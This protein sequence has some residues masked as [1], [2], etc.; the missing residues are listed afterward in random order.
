MEDEWIADRAHLR[1][2]WRDHPTWRIM[3]FAAVL[4]RSVG[5]V[6]T[7]LRRFQTAAADDD[8]VLASQSRA[9]KHPPLGLSWLVMTAIL[10]IRL[11]PPQNLRRIPG[12][13][14]IL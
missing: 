10:T 4:H 9:P 2:L 6:V 1:Q 5:W 13:K 12:P 14:A 3:D 7:W 8:T 11:H